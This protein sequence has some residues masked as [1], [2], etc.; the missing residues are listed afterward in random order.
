MARQVNDDDNA[1]ADPDADDASE[2]ELSLDEKVRRGL[3]VEGEVAPNSTKW[4]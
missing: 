4:Q 2:D 3:R 1:P